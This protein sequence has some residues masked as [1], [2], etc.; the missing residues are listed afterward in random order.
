NKVYDSI[1][2]AIDDEDTLD[3]DYIGVAKSNIFESITI[4][5]TIYLAPVTSY[6][7]KF[8]SYNNNISNYGS[9]C[10][11]NINSAII[12]LYSNSS[13]IEGFTFINNID[14][15]SDINSN[16]NNGMSNYSNLYNAIE[17]IGSYNTISNCIF[18]DFDNG[19][20]VR[21]LEN[22]IGFNDFNSSSAIIYSNSTTF[23]ANKINV[24]GYGIKLLNSDDSNILGNIIHSEIPLYIFNSSANINFN[25]IIS[26]NYSINSTNKV[27]ISSDKHIDLNNNWWGLNNPDSLNYFDDFKSKNVSCDSWLVLSLDSFVDYSTNS[28]GTHNVVLIGDLTH[29]N[30]NQ[31]LSREYTIDNLEMN[32]RTDYGTISTNLDGV[33]LNVLSEGGIAISNI[34]GP[35]PSEAY[36][37]LSLDNEIISKMI[38]LPSNTSY[39]VINNR[40]NK[41]YSSIQEAIDDN[42]TKNGDFILLKRGIFSENIFIYK[43][44]TLKS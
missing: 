34:Y 3:K 8:I 10:E 7:V 35:N 14:N 36:I 37:S 29:N 21:G 44:I 12:Y 25:N 41:S 23:E 38:Y 39:G 13:I 18:N 42:D 22:Y 32:F 17:V 30:L 4:N 28:S 24:D 9:V 2:E 20:I 5:K 11:N 33:N 19:V 26:V 31:D 27:Y 43:N 1:Q 16:F 15:N 40:S 6:I